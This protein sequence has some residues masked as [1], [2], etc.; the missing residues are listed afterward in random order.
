MLT[1]RA[2]GDTLEEIGNDLGVTRER[3]RQIDR[4]KRRRRED[5]LKWDYEALGRGRQE[6]QVTA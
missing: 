2:M 6:Q 1:R 5:G 3:I 4:P